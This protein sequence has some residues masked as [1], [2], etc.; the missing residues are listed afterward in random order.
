MTLQTAGSVL[1][2]M[3]GSYER[4]DGWRVLHTPGAEEVSEDDIVPGWAGVQRAFAKWL[5]YVPSIR[6]SGRP[7]RRRGVY[8]RR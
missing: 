3:D 5:S 2:Y 7:Q 4:E 8:W 1:P 6:I